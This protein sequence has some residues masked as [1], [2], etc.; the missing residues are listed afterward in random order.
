MPPADLTITRVPATSLAEYAQI[1]A[2]FPVRSVL[3][4]EVPDAGLA[5]MILQERAL[6]SPYEKD[7]DAL[8]GGPVGWQGRFDLTSWQLFLAYRAGQCLGGAAVTAAASSVHMG[9]GQPAL[10]VLWD[11]RVAPAARRQAVGTALFSAAA[12]WAEAQG[13]TRLLIETQNTNVPACRFYAR[14]GCQLSG[15]ERFAYPELPQ[16]VRLLW[17]KP[18]PSK[19]A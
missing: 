13:S 5:G 16:E 10:A 6:S 15:M 7:Y 19:N 4:V 9:E 8:D 11:L 17:C 12:D 3:D 2:R 18:L 1:S 14:Q